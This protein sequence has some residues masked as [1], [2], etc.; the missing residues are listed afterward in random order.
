MSLDRNVF[1]SEDFI[2]ASHVLA[3][4]VLEDSEDQADEPAVCLDEARVHRPDED[5]AVSQEA[6]EE[7]QSAGKSTEG[8]YVDTC[9][10]ENEHARSSNGLE[11]DAIENYSGELADAAREKKLINVIAEMP[12]MSVCGEE[13]AVGK[14]KDTA[15]KT[16]TPKP[17]LSGV[18]VM[19]SPSPREVKRR[20]KSQRSEILTSSLPNEAE[21]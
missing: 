10:Q 18:L 2:S 19:P 21:A 12:M 7:E 1:T 5:R 15:D 13:A 16:A 17:S 4:R 6:E 8:E 9:R 14:A 3:L 20:V 11:S